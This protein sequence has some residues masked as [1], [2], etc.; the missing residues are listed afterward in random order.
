MIGDH[1]LRLG[2]DD[3]TAHTV[4]SSEYAG[5]YVWVY[6][7]TNDYRNPINQNAGVGAP[8]AASQGTPAAG[9]VGYYVRKQYF[10]NSADV[11]TNQKAYYLE[12]RWQVNDNFMLSLGVRNENF[13]NYNGDH[14]VYVS[15]KNQWAP[16]VGFSWDVL[17]DQ[18]LKIFGNAGRYH[19]ALPNNVA[20]R[21]AANSLY[22]LEYFN[23]TGI[24]PVTG[25]P[26]GLTNIPVD[27][28]KGF[29]CPGNNFAIAPNLECGNAKDPRTV[30]AKDL[31]PHFQDEYILGF[32]HQ[33]NATINWGMRAHWRALKSAIDDTCTTVLGG[34][35]F[36]FNPGIGNTF[37]EDDG[38]GGLKA[39]H[40]TAQQLALPK[41][42]RK[43]WA[44][45]TFVERQGDKW[46]GRVEYSF[47]RNMGNTEGQLL[48]DIDTGGGGQ[49]DVGQT[50]DWDLP[51]LMEN[52]YGLLPNHRAHQI[53]A[54]GYYDLTSEFRV[55]ASAIITSGRPLSCTSFY[56]DP[57]ADTYNGSYYHWCGMAP[58]S[59]YPG[60]LNYVATPRGTTGSTGWTQA[61]NLNASYR[62]SFADNK[63]SF[64]VDVLNVLDQ[65]KAQYKNMQFSQD[66]ATPARTYGQDLSYTAPRSV[67]FTVRYDY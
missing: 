50:Q 40:Y 43:Y 14:K 15:Q 20:A 8:G 27:T 62:P 60:G 38:K 35:C 46:F 29:T 1:S 33:Y 64:A 61:I 5:G 24:D 56:P 6:S 18:S 63:L 47:S 10:T 7:R 36:I 66:R 41:L 23:Y 31:K 52:S 37:Y 39:V 30:A 53:K 55:G 67:R 48:S 4:G 54:Y 65:Q 57:D 51:S 12:D 17:G 21:A 3:S 49:S 16:R 11:E 19:L 25:A 28:T 42:K 2:Y 34:G 45:D 22:T 13:T 9:T 58:S 59:K 26:T 32:Q 44:I